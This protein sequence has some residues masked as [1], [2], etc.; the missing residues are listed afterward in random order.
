[1]K[2][3]IGLGNPG[4]RY[5]NTKHNVGFL[6]IKTFAKKYRL[7]INKKGFNGIYGT[8]KV[9]TE[10]VTLFEPLTYMNLSGVAVKAICSSRL[11]EENNLLII[12][13]DFNLPLGHIRLR[14]TGSHGGHN[15]LASIIEHIG[16]DFARL[17]IG[18]G[19][20]NGVRSDM[21]SYVLSPFLR[22]ERPILAGS[23]EKAVGCI[24]TWLTQGI[25]EA[26][27]LY[28]A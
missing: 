6:A 13:D 26:M 19:L 14:Q 24:E 16:P 9:R 11:D 7:R 21:T 12:S 25:T 22:K 4:F 23:I 2:I 3:I 18:I 1:M 10:E 5:R 27:N 15:G 20:A 17:R 8:G 28:N